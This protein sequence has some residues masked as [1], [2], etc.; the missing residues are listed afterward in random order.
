M[1]LSLLLIS[2]M[3]N[4]YKNYGTKKS[5]K[6]T[7]TLIRIISIN[8]LITSSPKTNLSATVTVINSDLNSTQI[9]LS[10]NKNNIYLSKHK[11]NTNKSSNNSNLSTKHL[12]ANSNSIILKIKPT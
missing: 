7:S 8:K 6:T 11:P 12:M 2:T 9:P 3:I 5:I 1:I 10:K 4:N